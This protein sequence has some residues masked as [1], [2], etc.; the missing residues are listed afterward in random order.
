MDMMTGEN[1]NLMEQIHLLDYW[2]IVKKRMSLAVVVF[3]T[4]VAGTLF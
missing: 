3:C 1:D 4:V 2:N